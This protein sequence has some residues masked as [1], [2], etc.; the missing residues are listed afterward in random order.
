MNTA[1]KLLFLG[2]GGSMGTP[3]VSCHC[4]VCSSNNP[5]NKRLRPSA[6]L[7]FDGKRYLIDCGPDFRIQALTHKI[8]HLDGIILTHS[9]HDHCSGIDELRIFTFKR[10]VFLPCIMSSETYEELLKRFYYIFSTEN[11]ESK[12]TT[13]F[14][15]VFLPGD[16][17]DIN[18][19]GCKIL[20][21]SYKQGG[22][23]VTGLR[24]GD[25]AFL[26]DVKDYDK[27]IFDFVSGVNT[28]VISALRFTPSPLHLNIDE[29][30][31][32]AKRVD[33]HHTWFTHISHELD[34]DAGNAYLPAN[35]RLAYDGLE[36]S[37]NLEKV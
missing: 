19:N 11:I 29:A 14:S 24:F 16:S 21:C 15:P 9:H 37:F 34:H 6:L 17:G 2:T 18:F 30:V 25:L 26:T 3:M 1:G 13:N 5:F 10:G 32:F 27:S 23:K 12:F 8:E 7:E 35:I 4:Q 20:Y 33:A 22:M 36:I 31:D 28:L